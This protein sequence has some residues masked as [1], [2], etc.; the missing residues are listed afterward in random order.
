MSV[1]PKSRPNPLSREGHD[2]HRTK[3]AFGSTAGP[4]AGEVEGE[5]ASHLAHLV[6]LKPKATPTGG[7]HVIWG[8]EVRL[9]LQRRQQGHE[10]SPRREGRQPRR[11]DEHG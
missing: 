2:Q 10:G 4:W 8:H 11:D 1:P 5:G 6:R 7:S 9:R 3:G